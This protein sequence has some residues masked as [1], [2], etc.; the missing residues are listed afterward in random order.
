MQGRNERTI[1]LT[2]A[3]SLIS[4]LYRKPMI[5][6]RKKTERI[7]MR[8]RKENERKMKLQ[9]RRKRKMKMIRKKNDPRQQRKAKRKKWNQ[10]NKHN[11]RA[12]SILLKERSA[13]LKQARMDRSSRY[14]KPM[15]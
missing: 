8:R 14:D 2:P 9:L 1:L 5:I 7:A 3:E 13:R 6:K 15:P 4:H 11:L 12:N 10:R